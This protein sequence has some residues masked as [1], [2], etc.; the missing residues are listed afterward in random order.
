MVVPLF[1][2]Y[3]ILLYQL[4]LPTTFDLIGTILSMS[5]YDFEVKYIKE[6]SNE[7]KYFVQ[8]PNFLSVKILKTHGIHQFWKSQNQ[9]QEV[10]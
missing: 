7:W 5:I 10:G 1:D 2:Y 6:P 8:I 4:L 9:K 3:R